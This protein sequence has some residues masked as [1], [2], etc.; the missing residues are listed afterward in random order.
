MAPEKPLVANPLYESNLNS[1]QKQLASAMA[2][3]ASNILDYKNFNR[4]TNESQLARENF[5]SLSIP[6]GFSWSDFQL[7]DLDTIPNWKAI[8]KN[9]DEN[10]NGW[11]RNI[12]ISN[13]KNKIK[14]QLNTLSA[15]RWDAF[16]TEINAIDDLDMKGFW[17]KAKEFLDLEKTAWNITDSDVTTLLSTKVKWNEIEQKVFNVLPDET[18]QVAVQTG[19]WERLQRWESVWRWYIW[20]LPSI[21]Q[22]LS[23]IGAVLGI[24]NIENYLNDSQYNELKIALTTIP[25]VSL[26]AYLNEGKPIKV[27]TDEWE[28]TFDEGIEHKKQILQAIRNGQFDDD[29]KFAFA[30]AF[31][32]DNESDYTFLFDGPNSQWDKILDAIFDPDKKSVT[33][34]F[35]WAGSIPLELGEKNIFFRTKNW[36][37]K[38]ENIENMAL[39]FDHKLK[40]LDPQF[41][42]VLNDI[43]V[44][45]KIKFWD[46]TLY[47]WYKIS[48]I[49]E[50]W[51]NIEGYPLLDMDENW[52]QILMLYKQHPLNYPSPES[53]GYTKNPNS[54]NVLQS[55]H[56]LWYE[57]MAKFLAILAW[58]KAFDYLT[59][60][61]KSKAMQEFRKQS[62]EA[63]IWNI[64]NY[65][66]YKN[67]LQQE[68]E[69]VERENQERLQKLEDE[70]EKRKIE[71]QIKID[72]FYKERENFSN[73]IKEK[74]KGLELDESWMP[75]IG[76]H[77]VMDMNL[78]SILDDFSQMVVLRIDSIDK[79]TNTMQLSLHGSEN[80]LPK[81]EGFRLP[82]FMSPDW[83]KS[84]ENRWWIESI[85]HIKNI[86][87]KS[88]FLNYIS[89]SWTEKWIDKNWLASLVNKPDHWYLMY[90]DWSGDTKNTSVMKYTLTDTGIILDPVDKNRW[91]A[92]KMTFEWFLAFMHK[93]Y[94]FLSNEEYKATGFNP[95]EHLPWIS[96][97]WKF[98]GVWA[99][100][101]AVKSVFKSW[102]DYNKKRDELW[103]AELEQWLFKALRWIPWMSEVAT[104]SW[105][106]K[107]SWM[108]DDFKKSF[109]TNAKLDPSPVFND[110]LKLVAHPK[111]SHRYKLKVAWAMLYAME[112]WG[113]YSRWLREVSGEWK[114]V[115]ALLWEW[116]RQAYLKHLEKLKSALS[117]NPWDDWILD[118]IAN[119]EVDYLKVVAW[120][121]KEGKIF[122]NMFATDFEDKLDSALRKSE[123]PWAI[124][125][126]YNDLKKYN[127]PWEIY[128]QIQNWLKN[129]NINLVI[130]G[131]QALIE[132]QPNVLGRRLLLQTWAIIMFSGIWNRFTKAQRDAFDKIAFSTAH[133]WMS[134]TL[135]SS[136]ATIDA[137]KVFDDLATLENSNIT[138]LWEKINLNANNIDK[139][140]SANYSNGL[141]KRI[142]NIEERFEENHN[143]ITEIFDPQNPTSVDRIISASI[144]K[145][146]NKWADIF[147]SKLN[148][149]IGEIG[150]PLFQGS[151]KKHNQ[152]VYSSLS[153]IKNVDEWPK[154]NFMTSRAKV[155]DNANYNKAIW[156]KMLNN[157]FTFVWGLQKF[158][159]WDQ[160]VL[161]AYAL[162]LLGK[163]NTE[164]IAELREKFLEILSDPLRSVFNVWWAEWDKDFG[165]R[166][167]KEV[168]TWAIAT[169][170]YF[171][172]VITSNSEIFSN[173][174]ELRKFVNN[175]MKV[176]KKDAPYW[177]VTRW[178]AYDVI[179]NKMKL[180]NQW[181]DE[182]DMAA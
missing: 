12:I 60:E 93:P 18:L 84:F 64:A 174:K 75:K 150:K 107:I 126:K 28:K 171:S 129:Q 90:S 156:E 98:V 71:D 135:K 50:N 54:V 151:V 24:E 146:S 57:D 80:K 43:W 51:K 4:F 86:K 177:T 68:K 161:E 44:D 176:D 165:A 48:A 6:W 148:S 3:K 170:R 39:F 140:N 99:A 38:G 63:N 125:E 162:A 149:N 46:K 62:Q 36:N 31:W 133:Y 69:R 109:D 42:D 103:Q 114:F 127:N 21:Q 155:L 97:P 169:E 32:L 139:I 160:N 143:I 159:E 136:S 92:Q 181:L 74:Y 163:K 152:W 59:N 82:I 53:V 9:L 11:I 67:Q 23:N 94:I 1:T 180:Y 122:A 77:F 45:R 19:A 95:N 8:I 154:L 7:S 182:Y 40:P 101:W 25:V 49:D 132:K 119:A 65:W 79:S 5:S 108:I 37:E 33:V 89:S 83:W 128:T 88:E 131:M 47:S 158:N 118:K 56:S 61:Q 164:Y 157:E 153:T 55:Q 85:N 147:M 111:W 123:N 15:G 87:N 10:W 66:D 96:K 16:E 13:F 2:Q 121:E 145:D 175:I 29:K 137:L 112:N 102:Q 22:K 52:N 70:K 134:W 72:P 141:D 142:K 138:T 116:H 20:R 110:I 73:F 168:Q 124:E 78:P 17:K 104:N 172:S 100:I 115:R 117:L 58:Y 76:Q 144:N 35:P 178:Q 130:W 173:P 105:N 26:F 91:W 179:N 120:H 14:T 166:F 113:L 34:D 106:S 27:E 167:P 41:D 30:Q 81:Y